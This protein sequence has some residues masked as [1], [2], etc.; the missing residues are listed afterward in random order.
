MAG[1]QV[2]IKGIEQLIEKFRQIPLT[3]RKRVLRNALAAGARVV[4]DDAKR[5]APLLS[6]A[7]KAPFRTRGTVR[8]AI[9]VRTSKVDRKAGNVGVFVNV[10]PLPG[11]KYKTVNVA[12]GWLGGTVKHRAL[13]KRSARGANNP[14]DPFYWRWL[15]FGTKKMAARSF[16]KPA[17]AKLGDALNIFEAKIGAWLKSVDAGGPIK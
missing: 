4:R 15:E 7:R 14:R 13:V 2:R 6:G 1:E 10:K 16:L 3:L 17:A 11:N 9:A 8:N 12:R 5:N